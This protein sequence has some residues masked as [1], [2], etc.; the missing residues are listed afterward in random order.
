MSA[1][2]LIIKWEAALAQ[3]LA[4]KNPVELSDEDLETATSE[5]LLVKSG[6]RAGPAAYSYRGKQKDWPCPWA[7]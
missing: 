3:A 7:P 2:D 4:G 1:R 6:L 5:A